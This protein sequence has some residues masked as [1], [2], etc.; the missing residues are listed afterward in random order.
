MMGTQNLEAQREAIL[1]RLHASREEYRRLLAGEGPSIAYERHVQNTHAQSVHDAG[2]S[3]GS[4]P[5][6]PASILDDAA[7]NDAGH[8]SHA[9][10][11]QQASSVQPNRV[12][13]V[14][15]QPVGASRSNPVLALVEQHPL[16]CAAVIA[17]LVAVGPRRINQAFRAT[18]STLN[19]MS[20]T[21]AANQ[22]NIETITRVLTAVAGMLQQ[23][24]R[25]QYP[26]RR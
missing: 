23:R 4:L 13:S 15:P 19:E 11:R 6:H 17:A 25:S 16:I 9:G 1:S 2:A 12:V 20:R 3:N 7:R 21:L 10:A 8:A 26:P 5:E 24:N 22:H 14:S 18:N